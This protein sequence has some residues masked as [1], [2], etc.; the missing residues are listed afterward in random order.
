[1]SLDV[2]VKHSLP[3]FEIDATFKA[4]SGVTV[5]FGPSGS[6]KTSIL[7]M[8]AGL[9]APKEGEIKLNGEILFSSQT[10]QSVKAHRRHCGYIFQEP[11][12]FPH[13]NVK[14]NLLYGAR[15]QGKQVSHAELTRIV[16]L[17]GIGP[18]LSRHPLTLS[19]GEQQRVAIG[20][21]LLTAPKVLLMDE[22]L[23]SLDQQRKLDLLPFIE[24]IC[25]SSNFPIVYVTHSMN[26]VLRLADQVVQLHK[27]KVQSVLPPHQLSQSAA[28]LASVERNYLGT[29]LEGHIMSRDGRSGVGTVTLNFGELSVPLTNA[30]IGNKVRLLIPAKD[31]VLA[32]NEPIG[33]SAQ[34]ILQASITMIDSSHSPYCTVTLDCGGETI[35]AQIICNSVERLGLVVGMPIYAIIKAVAVDTF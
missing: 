31:V 23:S 24:E 35:Y 3:D 15:T 29:I 2:T 19:G 13:Y 28:Y 25:R 8:I 30:E 18:L 11:R 6:G 9:I 4:Q 27:G 12:L 21:V 1:M 7:K 10:R 16:D 33:L 20:R 32:L 34:N 26:E 17:L 14:G 22:P 5:L